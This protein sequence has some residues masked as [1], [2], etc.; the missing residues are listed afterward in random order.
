MLPFESFELAQV[1]K[2]VSF[3]VRGLANLLDLLPDLCLVL[4]DRLQRFLDT[5]YAAISQVNVEHVGRNKAGLILAQR[6]LLRVQE[7][8]RVGF[9]QRLYAERLLVEVVNFKVQSDTLVEAKQVSLKR[10]GFT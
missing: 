4:F 10:V 5:R 8:E 1:A 3:F 6:L 9:E 7:A 2:E